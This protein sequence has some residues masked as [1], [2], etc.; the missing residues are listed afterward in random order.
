[1]FS[2][3]GTLEYYNNNAEEYV[4]RTRNI[5]I[6]EQQDIFLHFLPSPSLILDAG[7]GSGRDIKAFTDL[8]HTVTGIDASSSL[9]KLAAEY[10]NQKCL[11][12]PFQDIKWNHVFDGIWACAS[13]LHIKK[14]E[15]KNVILKLRNAL[16]SN[17]V[18]YISLREGK[19]ERTLSDGRYFSNYSLDEFTD[20]INSVSRLNILK[21]WKTKDINHDRSNIVWL[22][23]LIRKI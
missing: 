6:A 18:M 4:A 15:I 22:N 19:D 7:C 9:I 12:L 5:D 11:L 23:F 3:D 10:S 8:G 13:L 17:G 14:T 16:K 21:T 20:V 1:M 2:H